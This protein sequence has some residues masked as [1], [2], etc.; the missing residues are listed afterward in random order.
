MFRR[1][2]EKRVKAAIEERETGYTSLLIT[3]LEA[4]AA[5][6]ASNVLATGA[7]E[8]CAGIWARALAAADVTGTGALSRR[9]RHRIG[10]DLIRHGE[11]VHLVE[12]RPALR[13]SPVSSFDVRG[14]FRYEVEV[15]VPPGK[16]ERRNVHRDGV[17]HCQWAQ[18]PLQPWIGSGPL[19]NASLLANVA[20]RVESKMGEEAGAPT[21]LILPIP[22]DGGA[23]NLDALRSDIADAK[24]GA[25]LAEST[26]GG[27][28][29]GRQRGTREDWGAKRLGP[30]IP[31][32]LRELYADTLVRLAEACGIPSALVMGDADGTSQRESYRRFVMSSVEPVAALIAE[33]ASEKLETEVEFDFRGVWAHD[34]QGRAT[35]FQKLVAGGLEASEARRAVGL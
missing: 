9:V 16:V 22:T 10:R 28:D 17:L 25:V 3:G 24:G 18:D 19:Q 12:T 8:T 15:P 21:A 31:E 5:G 13:L 20:A 26:V 14:G 1:Y 23:T 30:E 32:E 4:T 2:I 7:A 35:A 34:I 11:S 33:E 6:T 27:W 29:E